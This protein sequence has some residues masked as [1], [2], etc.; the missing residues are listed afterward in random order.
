M[1]AFAGRHATLVGGFSSPLGKDGSPPAGKLQRPWHEAM[2]M[3]DLPQRTSEAT[4]SRRGS[5]QRLFATGLLLLAALLFGASFLDPH[6]GFWTLFLRSVTEASLVGGI[7]DWF[8]VVALFERP[9]G[10]PIPHTGVIPRNKDR[11]A[12]GLSRFVETHFLDPATITTRLRNADVSMLTARWLANAENAA[13]VAERATQALAAL[14]ASVPDAEL[15]ALVRRAALRGV[16][17]LDLAILLSLTLRVVYETGRH[18]ELFENAVARARRWVAEHPGRIHALV[19]ER[20]AWWVPKA[21]DRGLSRALADQVLQLLDE[22]AKPDCEARN[23]FDSLVAGLI[24]S[25]RD[26]PRYRERIE[27]IKRDLLSSGQVES[28]LDTAA[29]ELRRLALE[30]MAERRSSIRDAI[31]N[32]IQAFGRRLS[33]D[34]SLRRRLERRLI[35]FARSMVLPWRQ[36][37]GRFIADV[38][39]GWEARTVAERL[40]QAV[41]RDLQYVRINGTLVGGIVG[42]VLFLLTLSAP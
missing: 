12:T 34:E 18:Q 5:R 21:I 32:A 42:G 3:S 27:A 31:A 29:D 4:D 26:S 11:I 28:S 33:E 39:R 13:V 8:A 35:W 37:I 19:Q 17:R 6:P 20:T 41:G 9:L 15:R 10:L 14:V 40:E 24:E 30:D 25:L 22:L 38:M 2:A 16:S 36:N 1:I 7:A 23:D